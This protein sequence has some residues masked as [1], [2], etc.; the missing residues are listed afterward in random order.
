VELAERIA[1]LAN[2][3]ADL[4]QPGM[5]VGL[6]TGSTADAVVRELGRRASEG[7]TFTG[8]PT[9]C[10]TE[11]MARDLGIPLTT[12]DD[13]DRLD[14][15]IDGA[16]EIDPNLDAIKGRGGALLYEKLVALACEQFVLVATTE[17]N[18]ELLGERTALPVEIVCFGWRQ[19]AQRLQESGY[20]PEL[21]MSPAATEQPFV[22]DN[23]SYI[24]D[25]V[26]GSMDDPVAVAAAV[27]AVPGV[28]EHGLFV[29]IADASVQI[30]PDGSVIRRERP[31][32]P[33]ISA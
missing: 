20:P 6:G 29:G 5:T 9:S 14:L 8:V 25:C 10:R 28:I 23:G 26:T 13:I 12:L 31:Q 30:D 22:S 33:Q 17:K 7:L 27:K 32:T 16:D 4:V 19:T 15:G 24:L 11:A 3:A 18:V 2:V 1:R 21:R